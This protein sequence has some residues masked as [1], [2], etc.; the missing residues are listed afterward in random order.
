MYGIFMECWVSFKLYFGNP[1]LA[2]LLV[3]SA[4]YIIVTEKKWKRRIV[5]GV[6][7][8]VIMVGFLLPITKI[9]Y[10][11]VFNE[12]S[13]TYYRIMWLVPMY[14]VIG[15]A[16]CKL[17]FSFQNKMVQRVALVA[18]LA[19]TIVSGS[20][21][22]LNQY[23]SVA[24]NLY[25]IPQNVIDIC[26]VISP[27]EGE[28]R[29]R[30]AF[31]SELVHFVRQYNTDILL[32][33]GREMVVTQW[34]YYNPVYEVMENSPAAEAGIQPYDI[35]IKA[36]EKKITSSDDLVAVVSASIPGDI[37]RFQLFRQGKELEFDITIKVKN[38]SITKDT[39]MAA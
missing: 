27:A 15:Y 12:G 39:N 37:L 21:V 28:P 26:D 34:D 1:L 32:P 19:I 6:L 2:I 30:A 20:L 31:P 33:F 38:E 14:V 22:Y 24:E 17:V 25:H 10:V 18:A 9:V 29:V 7:P 8:L 5:L 11:A 36:G 13:D 35:I 4:I 16:L 23:M 3:A